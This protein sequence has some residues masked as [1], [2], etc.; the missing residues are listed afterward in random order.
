MDGVG[1]SEIA[2]KF[3][4]GDIA[5]LRDFDRPADYDRVCIEEQVESDGDPNY[6]VRGT[7]G[8]LPYPEAWLLTTEEY[9]LFLEQLAQSALGKAKQLREE[10]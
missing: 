10:F 9:C 4:K 2:F 5:W 3:A 6:R 8:V 7:W 1:E